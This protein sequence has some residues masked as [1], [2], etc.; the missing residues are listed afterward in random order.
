MEPKQEYRYP[1]ILVTETNAVVARYRNID[2]LLKD[3]HA[4]VSLFGFTDRMF[5]HDKLLDRR[6]RPIK[7]YV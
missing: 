5:V 7:E 2:D 1:Y 6:F 3:T 4:I